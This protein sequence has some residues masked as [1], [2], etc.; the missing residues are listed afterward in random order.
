MSRPSGTRRASSGAT[1]KKLLGVARPHVA[2]WL[3]EGLG[4]VDSV[5]AVTLAGVVRRWVNS[6]VVSGI[7]GIR[8][9]GWFGHNCSVPLS[10]NSMLSHGG[11]A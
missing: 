4:A 7:Y 3:V 6:R 11:D 2:L 10:G 1:D 8:F 5:F 9:G